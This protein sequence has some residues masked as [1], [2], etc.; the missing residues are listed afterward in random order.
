MK[1]ILL[2]DL[3]KESVEYRAPASPKFLLYDFYVL[4][5]IRTLNI[6]PHA[7]GFVGRFNQP[8]TLK[9][10]IEHATSVL[11]PHLKKHILDV[12]FF[13]MCAE[14]RHFYIYAEDEYEKDGT[15]KEN[16]M[17]AQ[18]L[19]TW[20]VVRYGKHGT[21]NV[22]KYK[23]VKREVPA[24]EERRD[25]YLRSWRAA[26]HVIEKTGRT[27]SEFVKQ[28]IEAFDQR[29]G[30]ELDYGGKAWQDICEAWIMLHEADNFNTIS[31]A[32]DH[33]YDLQHNTGFVLNKIPEYKESW[34]EKALNHKARVKDIRELFP[35]CSSDM[36]KLGQQAMRAVGAKYLEKPYKEEPEEDDPD[37]I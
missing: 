28:T 35:Y 12:L 3:L 21:P 16:P 11:L 24:G 5:Y 29:N 14:L 8:E 25:D 19:D 4:S 26:K 1:P 27:V 33:I 18:Y 10:D 13:C 22:E 9:S 30:W 36:R 23:S 2:K 20:K 7:K 32:I 34:V 37:K 6:D 31:V 15:L 17:I